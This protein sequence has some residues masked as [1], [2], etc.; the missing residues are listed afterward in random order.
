MSPAGRRTP[1][2]PRPARRGFRGPVARLR[3]I[4]AAVAA[5]S[6]IA[7]IAPAAAP[8]DGGCAGADIEVTAQ[9]APALAQSTVCL[10]NEQRAAAGLHTVAVEPALSQAA[11]DYSAE[12]VREAFFAHQ[13]PAGPDL[14][15]RLTQAGY[16]GPA[17]TGWIVGE[18]L[19]WAVGATATPRQLV[20]AWMQSPGHRRNVLEPEFRDI[21]IGVAA[22]VPGAGPDGVT[23]TTDFGARLS[24]PAP[25]PRP[26]AHRPARHR[27]KPCGP[28]RRA[29]APAR[30]RG[31]A[32]SVS[33][34]RRAVTPRAPRAQAR[35]DRREAPSLGPARPPSATRSAPARTRGSRPS[36]RSRAARP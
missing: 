5:L 6:A 15:G 11:A 16:L 8:A 17:A 26:R 34:A 36:T 21:G 14:A 18:N 1:G 32:A 29:D 30:Q 12:M 3:S 33:C 22:G 13:A 27:A 25:P 7:A 10:L 20:A 4:P 35:R 9:G 23:V 28:A 19:A 24:T 2:S 31:G